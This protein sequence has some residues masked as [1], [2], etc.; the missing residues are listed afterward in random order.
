MMQSDVVIGSARRGAPARAP[1]TPLERGQLAVTT[2]LVLLTAGAWL[3]TIHHTR[4]A[5]GLTADAGGSSHHPGH[6]AI[7]GAGE[8]AALGLAG[9]DWSP[10]G[11]LAFVI[12]W[13]VM[14][15]AMMFPGLAPMVLL[16]QAIASQRAGSGRGGAPVIFFVT[17]YL[18]VW[19]AVGGVL[20]ALFR[21]L[22]ELASRLSEAADRASWVPLVLGAALIVAGLYQLTPFKRACLDHCR[23]P[24][25]FVIQRWREGRMGRYGWASG[26]V[27]IVWA[28][29][30]H[31]SRC[32]WPRA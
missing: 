8:V 32:S 7:G 2:V 4:A 9:A 28:A 16:I 18:I 27:C 14:R 10:A 20:W 23:S 11:F 21:P 13:A 24:L 1:R 12:A 30:G 5:V 26:M 29:A 25:I 3:L 22:G 19:T 15:A 6:S 17:G 31:S